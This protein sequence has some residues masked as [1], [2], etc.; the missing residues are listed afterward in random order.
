MSL[1]AAGQPP[2][3]LPTQAQEV[4]D[5]TGAG[6]TVIATFGAALAAGL[7][8]AAAA[9]LANA[10]AGVVVARVGAASITPIELKLALHAHG[11]GP[12]DE[13]VLL[14]L[15]EHARSRGERIV[16]TNGCFDLLHAGHV[17]YLAEA[18]AL[19]ERLIVAVNDDAS[20]RRLKGESRPVVSLADRMAVLA[21]LADVDWVVPFSEDTPARLIEA[22]MPDVLVKGGDYH[23]NE[24]AGGDAVRRGGGEVRILPLLEGRSTSSLIDRIHGTR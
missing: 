15:V 22:V 10:A 6:D 12:V 5:V 7:E 8:S 17:R 1:I 20:V 14:N 2:V 23:P 11:R 24:V 16:M 4:A 9:S 3:H 18:R 13:A 21:A 19:G